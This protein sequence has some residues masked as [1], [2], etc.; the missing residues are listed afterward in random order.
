M[1]KIPLN[2]ISIHYAYIITLSI[3]SLI[4]L[5][6]YGNLKAIDAYFFGA[7]G[8]TESGLNTY[9]I[10]D[11]KTYQQL[12]IY[13]IPIISHLGFIN[14]AVVLV[15]LHWFK[16]RLN[17]TALSRVR[18]RH[19]VEAHA[20]RAPEE[21]KKSAGSN[22]NTDMTPGL[23][24][25]S[26]ASVANE[27]D[28]SQAQ[29]VK[30]TSTSISFAPD[31]RSYDK[32]KALYVPPPH[33]RD[34]G[35]PMVEVDEVFSGD[36]EIAKTNDSDV[37][38]RSLS[39]RR[40]IMGSSRIA[41]S[42]TLE[43]MASSIFVL[44]GRPST[45]N[46]QHPTPQTPLSQHLDLPLSSHATLGHNSQ[47]RNLTTED[48][49]KLGGIE[50]R[51]LKLLLKIVT[52]YFFG[53]HLFGAICLVGWIL[54]SDP[55]YR[56]YLGECGQSP[57]WWAF[58]SSQT[59]ISNLGF[60][61]TPDSMISFQ[62]AAWPMVLMSFLAYVGN[63][64]YP[65]F[66][67]FI[68][69]TMSLLVPRTS[70]LKEPLNF[71]LKHPRRCY[72]LLFPS[73][74]TWALFAGLFFLNFVDVV[75]MVTLDLNNPAVNNLP[76]GKRIL[77]S[78]FQA[79]STRHTGTSTFNLAKVNP[80]VQVSI[81]IMMYIAILPIALSI[82]ASNTYEQR[83]LGI[84][85]QDRELDEYNGKTYI[86]AHIK[87]QLT[88]DLWY[89]F[90]GVFCICA[91][92]S[93]RIM[94]PNEPA[95]AVFAIFFEVV[96]GYGNVGLSLGHPSVNTSLSGQFN[97]FS[98]LVICAMMIRGRHRGLPSQ[99]DRAVMLPSDRLVDDDDRTNET[100]QTTY[101]TKIK[102]YHTR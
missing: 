76:M 46:K 71:L 43:R 20:V 96:S 44:E 53:L 79:A 59:M 30:P 34:R 17:E 90:L 26:T 9:D 37:R 62:D 95:F 18:H 27:P 75:L 41:S 94:D 73:G 39:A 68:I 69:W 101:S 61:L 92:E 74:T 99:L 91:S 93:K 16:K 72:T 97:V 83:S 35:R 2:F 64:F 70:S 4:V 36:E 55:K 87:N 89:I 5:Y 57:V 12:F 23:N 77:A 33:E 15:R 56:K 86:L 49:E 63:T 65:C 84:Y 38:R 25:I 52:A 28:N 13:V 6:P 47:F 32:S 58:Y 51:S 1:W 22:G 24:A 66:L 21:E 10:K 29:T 42:T 14:I 98:K 31:V 82:R 3:S 48:R 45:A 100:T 7:S 19:D 85:P 8:C 11:L 81:L 67:R 102:R 78:I 88:F 50:Y 40:R 54:H 80:A 60:T